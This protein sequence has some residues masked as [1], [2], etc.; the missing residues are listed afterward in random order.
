MYTSINDQMYKYVVLYSEIYMVF[1]TRM[2]ADTLHDMQQ[3]A[4]QGQVS[5]PSV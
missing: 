2:D 5:K 4:D 1:E 3:T